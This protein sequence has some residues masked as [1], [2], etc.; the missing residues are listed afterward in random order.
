MPSKS[1]RNS[2]PNNHSW[3][4]K[5]TKSKL[6][7]RVKLRPRRRDRMNKPPNLRCLLKN[8]PFNN[9][10]SSKSKRKWITRRNK[11]LNSKR[12]P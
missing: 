10:S 4:S 9:K 11:L 1:N 8:F 7:S 3:S 6:K 5:Y 12:R 2:R